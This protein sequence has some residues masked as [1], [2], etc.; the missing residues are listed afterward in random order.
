MVFIVRL[1]VAQRPGY[2]PPT[3][4]IGKPEL[5]NRFKENSQTTTPFPQNIYKP[6][7]WYW[8]DWKLYYPEHIY[9]TDVGEV[10]IMTSRVPH[11]GIKHN[12]DH[13]EACG[14]YNLPKTLMN[15]E[16]EATGT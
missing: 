2:L 14:E 13:G 8:D 6:I 3:G 4:Y 7:N 5:A 15:V 1:I 9:G 11:G 16:N 10:V 12:S